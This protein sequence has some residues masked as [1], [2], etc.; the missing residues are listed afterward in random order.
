MRWLSTL[1]LA[2][3]VVAGA[4]PLA[5]VLTPDRGTVVAGQYVAIGGAVRPGLAGPARMQQIGHT[6]VDLPGLRVRGPLRP[7]V[8]LGPLVQTDDVS[9]LLDPKTGRHARHVAVDAVTKAA[10][11]WFLEAT[12]MLLVVALGLVALATVVR[13]WLVLA[14][15]HEH[16]TVAEVWHGH[17]RRFRR[18]AVIALLAALVAWG[19]SGALTWRDTASGLRDVSSL[20][21]L[22]GASPVDLA[23]VGAPVR[24]YA[25][26]VIGDSRASRLGGPLVPDPSRDDKACARSSDS[27]ASQLTLLNPEQPALNL[28]CPS[29]TI[30]A[31]LLGPQTRGSRVVPPQV[32]RLLQV[33]DLRYVAVMIGPNDLEWGDFLRYCYGVS[34]C[35]DAFTSTQF[36]YRLAGFDR[37]YG[38]LLAALASL[39]THPRV[40]I[41]GSYDVFAADARC[42]DTSGPPGVPGLDRDG[43]ALLRERNQ[44][45]NDV[46]AA[47]AKAYGFTM[48]VPHLSPLCTAASSE[49]G[50][51]IQGLT[52][53]YPFHP[54][55]IGMVRLGASV[56]S[57]VGQAE[58]SETSPS[59][60]D[61]TPA[62][63]GS[64]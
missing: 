33:H 37:D 30:E 55:A 4:V 60:G 29:A 64:R 53:R 8:V 63:P 41:V 7:E 9:Q 54:T 13:I 47:G 27:L 21:Q 34:K 11:T 10:R 15:A 16:V 18:D 31:G 51:D 56:L 49:L 17:A 2:A 5:I 28:A 6:T 14:R 26:A 32:A 52:D 3:V 46:L 22:V 38:D 61:A 44:R 23:P 12:G 48:A 1:V 59:P 40:V 25:G 57:A 50:Q 58:L 24:G 43:I 45:F 36:D 39:P 19:A 35:D 20:R 42:S 62:T